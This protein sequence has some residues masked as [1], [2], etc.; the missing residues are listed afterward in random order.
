MARHV[1]RR[2]FT[3]VELLVVIGIIAVLIAT[4][5]PSLNKARESAK[6]VSCMSNLRQIG[7]AFQIY[8]AQNKNAVYPVSR[9]KLPSGQDVLWY[10]AIMNLT[11]GATPAPSV[12]RCPNDPQMTIS[13]MNVS[14]G[15]N[16]G[17][18]GGCLREMGPA[19]SGPT[20]WNGRAQY[21]MDQDASLADPVRPGRVKQPVETVLVVDSAFT[22]GAPLEANG[23]FRAINF[24]DANGG[25]FP[26]HNW[27]C[28]VLW[29][30][31]HVTGVRCPKNA[32][33]QWD[34]RLYYTDKSLGNVFMGNSVYNKWDRR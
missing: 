21:V 9:L 1:A 25:A 6:S 31:G 32:T 22:G 27:Y 5:L 33:G 34:W 8:F 4:L 24:A 3:L 12:M 7:Q 15:Y 30:D 26:R 16:W 17:G 14:Y 13:G 11:P 19:P 10:E 18:L 29:I 28:N 20:T 2:G 23:W